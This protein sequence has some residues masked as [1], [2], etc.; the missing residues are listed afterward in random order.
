[1]YMLRIAA[2]VALTA[3]STLALSE[4]VRRAMAQ[5]G[6]TACEDELADYQDEI[7][8]CLDKAATLQQARACSDL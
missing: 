1:M 7:K 4:S 5:Q 2:L 3:I 8:D 6:T